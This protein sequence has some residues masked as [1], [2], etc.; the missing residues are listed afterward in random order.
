[1]KKNKSFMIELLAMLVVFVF[2]ILVMS[3]VYA[4]SLAEAQ[5]AK[6]LNDAVILASNAAEVFLSED[7]KDKIRDVLNEGNNAT[8]EEDVIA[9][10]NDDLQPDANGKMKVVI[11]SEKKDDFIYGTIRVY[12]E[13]REVYEIRTGYLSKEEGR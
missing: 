1:M 2:V 11:H 7:E 6:R 5:E 13:D 9:F 12:Y 3:R 8:I 4:R 10:Y